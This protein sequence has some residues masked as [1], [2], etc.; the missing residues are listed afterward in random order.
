MTES[1]FETAVYIFNE[2]KNIK[3]TIEIIKRF[4]EYLEARSDNKP[5]VTITFQ[6]KEGEYMKMEE[7]AGESL[8]GV[9]GF[10]LDQKELALK[11]LNQKLESI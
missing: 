8:D 11:E 1:Q 9:I 4:R 5:M 2:L 3:K 10:C 6:I 7:L